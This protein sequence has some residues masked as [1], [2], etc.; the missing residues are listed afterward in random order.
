MLYQ[1]GFMGNII[2]EKKALR[3]TL[4]GAFSSVFVKNFYKDE[5]GAT[6]IEYIAM[7]VAAIAFV[8]WF[9]DFWQAAILTAAATLT[10]F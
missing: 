5:T 10:F 1:E 2:L 6:T 8:N 7:A 9:D 3:E 4:A